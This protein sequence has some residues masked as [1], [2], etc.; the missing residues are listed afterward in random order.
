MNGYW[1]T[2]VVLLQKKYVCAN[3][4]SVEGVKR[5]A[6]LVPKELME[7]E[8]KI[9][10]FR[11]SLSLFDSH[12]PRTFPFNLFSIIYGSINNNDS[13]KRTCIKK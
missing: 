10:Y 11:A 6:T 13:F 4:K 12:T 9:K 2:R 5:K 1:I 7:E 3:L 8:I